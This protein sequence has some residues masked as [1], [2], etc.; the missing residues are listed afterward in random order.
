MRL[1]RLCAVTSVLLLLTVACFAQQSGLLSRPFVPKKKTA[2]IRQF[3]ESIQRETGIEISWSNSFM[4]GSRRVTVTGT[5]Q[6]VGD[7]LTTILQDQP[8]IAIEKNGNILLIPSDAPA[9]AEKAS[10]TINGYIRDAES[11]E[12][13]IGAYLIIPSLQLGV[14]TNVYGY[15]S[16]TVPAGNYEAVVAYIGYKADTVKLQLNN[17]FRK[18]FRILQNPLEEVVVVDKDKIESI[19][20]HVHLTMTDINAHQAL[21]GET[22]VMR[23]LQQI[24]GVQT[25]IDGGSSIQ[26]RGGD[27]GQNLNLLDGSPLY[28][29]DHF[30]GLSSVYN[31]EAL[32][33]VDFHKGAFPARYSGRLSSIVDV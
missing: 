19:S 31:T 7:V 12:V 2:S 5:E 28:F 13:L 6:T 1:L 8:V 33:S 9:A 14:V 15:Y 32:K 22:D 4:K 21:L 26:V 23:A 16:L 20:D 11:K 3:I 30:F 27:P 10:C 24:P 25:T 17:D 29:I 18:D